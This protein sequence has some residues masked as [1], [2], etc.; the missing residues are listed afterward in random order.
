MN[1][2]T[3]GDVMTR[4]AVAVAEDTPFRQIVDTME[5]NGVNAVPVADRGNRVVGVVTSADLMTKLEFAGSA[6]RD[7]LFETR[8]HRIARHK[9]AATEAAG[10]MTAPATTVLPATPIMTASKIMNGELKRLPVVGE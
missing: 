6:G 8:R 10:L 4:G 3:V 7:G 5:A 2:W 1:R 9:A